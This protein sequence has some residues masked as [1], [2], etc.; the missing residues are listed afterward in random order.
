MR[1]T[2]MKIFIRCPN[3]V[4]DVVMATPVFKCIRQNFPDAHITAGIR[5]Y[6]Y[7]VIEDGPW[8]DSVLFCEDKTLGGLYRTCMDVRSRRFDKAVLLTNSDRAFLIAFLGGIREIYGYKRNLQKFFIKQGPVPEIE[9]EKIKAIPMTDYYIEICRKMNLELPPV[10][11]PELFVRKELEVKAA[12]IL[13]KHGIS[14]GDLVI[15]I[16]PGAKFG[17]SKCWPVEYFAKFADMASERLGA[18]IIVFGGPGEAEIT[19]R[20]EALS[21]GIT[22]NTAKDNAGLGLSLLKAMIKKCRLLVTNDTGPRHYAT[23]FGIYSIVLMGSTDPRFV[24]Y[25]LDLMSVIRKDLEC[26]PCQQKICPTG[27]HECMTSIM[28]E[29]V[30]DEMVEVLNKDSW[31]NIH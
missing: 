25:G 11:T 8:F 13:K 20:I 31:V 9:N 4:G 16:N 22:I 2:E 30:F 19:G 5:K 27:T 15:G 18:K 1:K 21:K 26:S 10:P 3:W 14:D 6:A 28:P 23:A 29:M 24:E 17:S 12:E 7:G